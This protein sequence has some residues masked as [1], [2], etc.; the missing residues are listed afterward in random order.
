MQ[1]KATRNKNSFTLYRSKINNVAYIV[2]KYTI[3]TSVILFAVID[4][5]F[6]GKR[7][8]K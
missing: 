6:K 8:D 5:T 1:Y 4:L 7:G 2:K 3:I